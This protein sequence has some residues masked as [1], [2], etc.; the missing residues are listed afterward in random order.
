MGTHMAAPPESAALP[1]DSP[2]GVFLLS[3][4]LLPGV[5]SFSSS[6][7]ARYRTASRLSG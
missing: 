1:E 2:R 7:N 5:I 6:R 3:C 4:G